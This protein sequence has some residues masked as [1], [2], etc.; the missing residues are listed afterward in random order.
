MV[1]QIMRSSSEPNSM[2]AEY[3]RA[4]IYISC[5]DSMAEVAVVK[6]GWRS[7]FWLMHGI[8]SLGQQ[9]AGR[10]PKP[11]HTHETLWHG[12]WMWRI[13]PMP[14]QKVEVRYVSTQKPCPCGARHCCAMPE[15]PTQVCRARSSAAELFQHRSRTSTAVRFDSLQ[16]SLGTKPHW[17]CCT[18]SSWREN[19]LRAG[20]CFTMPDTDSLV[21]LFQ[22]HRIVWV[23]THLQRSGS[24]ASSKQS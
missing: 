17:P 16:H 15:A 21:Y 3:K 18:P 14:V 6:E 1:K 10:L 12:T 7:D 19:L 20:V 5:G 23:G 9:T 2:F 11:W 22:H 4:E 13:S 24:S 8:G